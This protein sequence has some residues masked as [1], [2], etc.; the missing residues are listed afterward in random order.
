MGGFQLFERLDQPLQPID[1]RRNHSMHDLGR[2]VRIL[3][4]KDALQHKLE[5]IV[6]FT[7][8][9]EIKDRGESDEISKFIVILQTSWFIIQ[10]IARSVNDLPLTELE[11]VTLAYGMLNFF[12]Y[13]FWWDKP[14]N[15]A[16]WA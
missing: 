12:V 13:I 14:R 10:C 8:E 6:P 7:T 15:V 1:G 9:E 2:F 16:L 11:I 5:I 4:S 3:E